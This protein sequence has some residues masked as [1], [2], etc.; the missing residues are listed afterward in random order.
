MKYETKTKH[1]RPLL[2]I[3]IELN[4]IIPLSSIAY[5]PVFPNSSSPVPPTTY[6]FVVAPR[7]ADLIHL[8]EG[9]MIS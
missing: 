8:I 5:R 3:R 2:Y 6:I 4:F 7:Q 1:L 9:L